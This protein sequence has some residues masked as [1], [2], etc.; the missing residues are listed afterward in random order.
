MRLK[1]SRFSGLTGVSGALLRIARGNRHATRG[2]IGFPLNCDDHEHAAG[3]RR[4][5]VPTIAP[6]KGG[7][8]PS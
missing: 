8:I 6:P 7:P 3:D 4:G 1:S 2:A 5:E